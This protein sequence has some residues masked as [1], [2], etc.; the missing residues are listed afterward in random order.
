MG[1]T[2]PRVN[3]AVASTLSM[4]LYPPVQ[5]ILMLRAIPATPAVTRTAVCCLMVTVALACVEP[6]SP[7]KMHRP[8]AIAAASW[9]PETPPFNNEV[10]LR[11]PAD[12][13]GAQGHVKFRQPNDAAQTIYLDVWVRDLAPNTHYRLQRAADATVDDACTSTSWLTLGKGATAQDI[14]TDERGTGREEL[15]RTLTNPPG[16]QFDIHFRVID[17]ITSA[18][19]LT[20]ACYQFV[21]DP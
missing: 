20:S 9:G 14:V 2:G 3:L 12:Q 8:T 15:F 19:V 6:T 21:V 17:A 5:E 1:H 13:A 10:I 16:T 18:V 11:D 4:G 7:A